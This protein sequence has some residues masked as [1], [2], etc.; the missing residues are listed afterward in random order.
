LRQAHEN[1]FQNPQNRS[2]GEIG[3]FKVIAGRAFFPKRVIKKTVNLS[4]PELSAAI[5]EY[6]AERLFK[7]WLVI[8][9]E[10]PG[11]SRVPSLF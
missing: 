1:W 8:P 10:A 2:F 4:G 7:A 5:K 3:Q 6:K 9:E 11:I